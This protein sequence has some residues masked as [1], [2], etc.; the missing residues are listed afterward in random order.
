MGSEMGQGDRS[1]LCQQVLHVGTHR[2]VEDFELGA[3]AANGNLPILGHSRVVK[4]QLKAQL[5]EGELFRPS[6]QGRLFGS[7]R[8]RAGGGRVLT[9]DRS[10]GN[11]GEKVGHNKFK[12]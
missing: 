6:R 11:P 3:I 2:V 5:L 8:Q 1:R 4:P 9:L 12:I 10:V 7:N